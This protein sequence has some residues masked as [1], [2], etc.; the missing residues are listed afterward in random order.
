MRRKL[1]SDQQLDIIREVFSDE[2][3]SA[4]FSIGSKKA[5]GPDGYNA[6]FFM[7][8]WEVVGM[9][10][11]SAVKSFFQTGKLL[12]AWNTTAITFIPKMSNPRTM[13]DFRPISCCNVV[14]KCIS[15]VLVA[16]L[17]PYLDD[18]VG[19]QQSP[20]V[21][22]LSRLKPYLADNI[23]LMQELVRGYHRRGGVA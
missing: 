3:T 14:Y 2:I 17:K 11:V 15:K 16:R 23:L 10:V 12:K 4:M 22:A 9:D 1:R 7:A 5:L 6:A 20:F 13:K 18:L 8:N 21:Q 19:H